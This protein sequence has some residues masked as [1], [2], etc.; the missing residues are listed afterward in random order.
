MA[1]AMVASIYFA[2][3][4]TNAGYAAALTRLPAVPPGSEPVL[5]AD[6]RTACKSR[7]PVSAR[8]SM[9]GA[10]NARHLVHGRSNCPLTLWAS[11]RST[12]LGMTPQ[13]R[14][15]IWVVRD[16]K[17]LLNEDGTPEA[18]WRRRRALATGTDENG[19]K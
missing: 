3:V 4:S 10:A 14:P 15:G 1:L 6:H 16:R 11:G 19:S 2:P 8:Q 18:G 13:C 9:D 5:L 12:E 7:R 17:P